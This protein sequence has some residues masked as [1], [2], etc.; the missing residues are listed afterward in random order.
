MSD[1]SLSNMSYR[2]V[3]FNFFE[4]HGQVNPFLKKKPLCAI[5]KAVDNCR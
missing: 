2:N 4:D 1:F 3:V 5:D